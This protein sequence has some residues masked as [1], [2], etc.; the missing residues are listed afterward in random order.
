[1]MVI[2]EGEFTRVDVVAKMMV[3]VGGEW[4]WW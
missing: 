4:M 3:M 2:V 1:V